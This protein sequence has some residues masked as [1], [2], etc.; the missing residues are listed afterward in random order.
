MAQP[1]IFLSYSHEDERLK[2]RVV[3]QLKVLKS[4]GIDVWSDD[5]IPAGGE[6]RAEIDSALGRANAAV[7]LVTASFLTSDFIL[8]AEV[9]RI[10][11][12]HASAGLKIFP[13]IAKP[14]AWTSVEWL[15]K[16][17]ALPKDGKPVWGGR[18][19]AESALAEITRAIEAALNAE[20]A[21]PPEMPPD[22]HAAR[23]AR[24]DSPAIGLLALANKF[25]KF[26]RYSK[27]VNIS[28][29]AD[30]I[31]LALEHGVPLYNGGDKEG[32]AEVY[33]RASYYLIELLRKVVDPMLIDREL[34]LDRMLDRFETMTSTPMLRPILGLRSSPYD[35]VLQMAHDELFLVSREWGARRSRDWGGPWSMDWTGREDTD[36]GKTA[37]TVRHVFDSILM[38]AAGV[39]AIDSALGQAGETWDARA[40][41]MREVIKKANSSSMLLYNEG[42]MR[43]QHWIRAC[44]AIYLHAAQGLLPHLSGRDL[45]PVRDLIVDRLYGENYVERANGIGMSGEERN[46]YE[47]AWV[48][49]H[50]FDM[51]ARKLP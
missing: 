31:G 14:C 51:L 19:D 47:V 15:A 26:N 42:L 45:A 34:G 25:N 8:D 12:R 50:A 1:L 13:V 23:A 4:A 2:D 16:M 9:P 48:I 40:Q 21:T 22:A 20:R 39:E 18:R 41:L 17:Q 30:F 43:G 11:E 6:W 27:G 35:F 29:V 24:P 10:I 33:V 37:W 36:P 3:R 5:R 49:R 28:H 38:A 44:A 46:A 7:L 32:C